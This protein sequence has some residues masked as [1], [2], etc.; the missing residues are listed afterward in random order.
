MHHGQK[1]SNGR[2][3]SV[4]TE[5][6][7]EYLTREI[8]LITEDR[9]VLPYTWL[10]STEGENGDK[11]VRL[12]HWPHAEI[13]DNEIKSLQSVETCKFTTYPSGTC[14]F[15]MYPGGTCKFIMYPGST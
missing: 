3:P 1:I 6:E 7:W 10:P 8:D 9:L 11:L 15:K 14:K 12:N 13:V 5:E 2:V 4:N